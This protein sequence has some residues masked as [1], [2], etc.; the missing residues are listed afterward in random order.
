[1]QY[2]VSVCQIDDL[3]CTP[4]RLYNEV[5]DRVSSYYEILW[6][7]VNIEEI[8]NELMEFQNRCVMVNRVSPEQVSRAPI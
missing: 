7:E 5:I 1:M 6:E 2:S 8:N 3:F 4:R